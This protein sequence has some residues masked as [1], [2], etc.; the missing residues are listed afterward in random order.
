MSFSRSKGRMLGSSSSF[1]ALP[2]GRWDMSFLVASCVLL[3]S[4]ASITEENKHFV[5]NNNEGGH[6]DNQRKQL[7]TD[8]T[9]TEFLNF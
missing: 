5:K 8:Y 9:H 3:V 2:L 6:K 4:T 1:P 7:G